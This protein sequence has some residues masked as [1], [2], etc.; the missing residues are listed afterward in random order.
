M[1]TTRRWVVGTGLSMMS[2]PLIGAALAPSSVAQ[3]DF[4][5]IAS[6]SLDCMLNS[7]SVNSGGAFPNPQAGWTQPGD[8]VLP[9][10]GGPPQV[11]VAPAPPMMPVP[12]TGGGVV[13][14]AGPPIG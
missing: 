8:L 6:V 5:C 7:G 14:P 11:A 9:A 1:N 10:A 3:P 2:L 13:I 4:D 12:T